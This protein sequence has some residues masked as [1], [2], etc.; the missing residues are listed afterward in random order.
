MLARAALAV[1]AL[2]VGVWMA[3]LI[4]DAHQFDRATNPPPG[5]LAGLARDLRRPGALQARIDPLRASTSL[6]PGSAADLQIALFYEIR[7][8]PGDFN[9]GLQIAQSVTRREPQNLTAWVTVYRIER[10][11]R[12]AAG[13]QAAF[14]HVRQLDPR[15]VRP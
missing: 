15:V 12:D 14:N 9:R 10:D 3:V 6:N 1:T 5:G 4:H 2:I 8:L 13:V 11:K 7:A